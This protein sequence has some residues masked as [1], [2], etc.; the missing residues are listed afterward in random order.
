MIVWLGAL[1]FK[2]REFAVSV[3]SV[4]NASVWVRNGITIEPIGVGYTVEARKSRLGTTAKVTNGLPAG[5]GKSNEN[6][7]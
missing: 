6:R 3:G 2:V 5:V 1:L 4:E 7:G